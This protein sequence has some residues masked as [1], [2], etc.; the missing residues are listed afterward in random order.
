MLLPFLSVYCGLR[1]CRLNYQALRCIFDIDY[2]LAVYN[3]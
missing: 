1:E 2:V 3:K